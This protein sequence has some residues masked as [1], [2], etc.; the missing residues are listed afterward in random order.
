MDLN[1]MY[2]M[3]D[4]PI[5]M[6]VCP[7]GCI[8]QGPICKILGHANPILVLNEQC[9]SIE[10]KQRENGQ[11]KQNYNLLELDLRQFVRAGLAA[12]C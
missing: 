1:H 4:R 2:C 8:L 11:K 10:S 7:N 6:N 5:R 3:C 12:M 9:H